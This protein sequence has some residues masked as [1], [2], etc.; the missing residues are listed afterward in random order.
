MKWRR[1]WTYGN[2][3][4]AL[5]PFLLALDNPV[6]AECTTTSTEKT[7]ARCENIAQCGYLWPAPMNSE[8]WLGGDEQA[9]K[10]VVLQKREHC[11]VII[12]LT[13]MRKTL[14]T[15][16]NRNHRAVA[17][18]DSEL[19]LVDSDDEVLEVTIACCL[20]VLLFC[21][22]GRLGCSDV[23]GFQY[24]DFLVILYFVKFENLTCKF[25]GFYHFIYF[26]ASFCPIWM[27]IIWKFRENS[28]LQDYC[29]VSVLDQS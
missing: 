28:G 4:T 12:A 3:D 1:E 18:T 8:D 20:A 7:L 27:K 13:K 16:R 6:L 17:D 25:C 26:S 10:N 29:L 19:R 15:L 5:I 14:L 2:H 23:R 21:R 22:F 9:K 11:L 24:Q